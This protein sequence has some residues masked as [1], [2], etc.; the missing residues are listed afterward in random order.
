MGSSSMAKLWD[1][2]PYS[3]RPGSQNEWRNGRWWSTTALLLLPCLPYAHSFFLHSSILLT[4]LHNI[5]RQPWPQ[6][7]RLRYT[8]DRSRGELLERKGEGTRGKKLEEEEE[9]EIKTQKKLLKALFSS[10]KFQRGEEK[11]T[12]CANDKNTQPKIPPKKRN[13]TSVNWKREENPNSQKREWAQHNT[14]TDQNHV[15]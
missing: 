5:E 13:F 12:A 11:M 1:T 15:F 3:L 14:K 8:T 9:E 10:N 4:M 2:V 6:N 7:S